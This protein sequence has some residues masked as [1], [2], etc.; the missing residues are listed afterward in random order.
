MSNKSLIDELRLSFS[1][2]AVVEEAGRIGQ[3]TSFAA[4]TPSAVV[5]P[6]NVAEVQRVVRI[7][8]AHGAPLYPISRGN[9]W[10]Y[11]DACA[12]QEGSLIV[13]LSRMNRIIEVNPE[14]AYAVVE[15]GVSQHQLYQHIEDQGLPLWMD[16]LGSGPDAS[17]IGN[18]MERGFGL[19][20]Y[21]DR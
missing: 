18:I 3:T 14:L 8:A 6:E 16:V 12:P 13:N 5:Y 20:P 10:G 9:N 4:T 7:A 1:E 21:S 19:G 15:P 11:G 2:E 17:I